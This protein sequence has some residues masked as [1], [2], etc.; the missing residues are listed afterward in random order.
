MNG[1][2]PA[3]DAAD[4]AAAAAAKSSTS[5]ADNPVTARHGG[6]GGGGCRGC[7]GG[8]GGGGAGE[9]GLDGA[10]PEGVGRGLA[11][12]GEVSGPEMTTQGNSNHRLSTRKLVITKRVLRVEELR[13]DWKI[14]KRGIEKQKAVSHEPSRH[15]GLSLEIKRGE[16]ALS[17]LYREL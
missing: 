15:F 4:A 1:Q 13:K 9:H 16:P 12:G 5:T 3:A 14:L 17:K 11:P 7:R 8:D 2:S 6:G 10:L